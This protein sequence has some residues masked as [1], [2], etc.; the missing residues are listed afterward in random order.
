[1]FP[2]SKCFSV[3]I[4]YVWYLSELGGKNKKQIKIHFLSL[5]GRGG[6]SDEC[7]RDIKENYADFG[8]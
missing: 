8:E 5:P 6:S 4:K 1:M 3:A 7:V 2:F